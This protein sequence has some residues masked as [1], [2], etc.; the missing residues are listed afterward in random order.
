MQ[1]AVVF[2]ARPANEL[3]NLNVGDQ[4]LPSRWFPKCASVVVVVHY[5]MHPRVGKEG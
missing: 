3:K 2:Q 1:K 5:H 4:P